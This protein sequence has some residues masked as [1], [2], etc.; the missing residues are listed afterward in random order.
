MAD[1]QTPEWI[2]TKDGDARVLAIYERHYSSRKYKDGRTRKLFVGPGEKMVLIT[3]DGSAILLWRRF[4][5]KNKQEGVNCAAFRNEGRALSSRLILEAEKLAWNRWPGSRLYTYVDPRQVKSANPG[6][7][8]KT[9]GWQRCGTTK[10]RGLLILEKIPRAPGYVEIHRTRG[11]IAGFAKLPVEPQV[12]VCGT[13]RPRKKFGR[14]ANGW[15]FPPAVEE[16][17][18]QECQGSTVLQL[19]GG[20]ADFGFR[21]DIDPETKPDKLGDAFLAHKYFPRDSYDHVIIDPPYTICRKQE[22]LC[23]IDTAAWIARK[24]IWWFH[25]LQIATHRVAPM[26]A[27]WSCLCGDQCLA[28]VLQRFKVLEPKRKP[29][30][31]GD[32][33]R[34]QALK[35]NRWARVETPLPFPDVDYSIVLPRPQ[36]TGNRP[37]GKEEALA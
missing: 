25:T 6:Y 27:I 13:N 17:L 22:V 26:D 20:L 31:L 9:A 36:A 29:P 12:L 24:Y 35:Y 3:A 28:R 30:E 33:K 32:F 34:G 11:R 23:L 5:S 10:D 7:C 19:F 18:L 2:E 1:R 21:L 8:F 16:L 4:L 37:Q 15:A 14:R